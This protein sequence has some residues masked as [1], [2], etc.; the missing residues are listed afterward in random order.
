MSY[1]LVAPATSIATPVSV[2][3]GGT[4]AA[5]AAGAKTNLSAAGSGANADI[6]SMTGATEI[7]NASLKLGAVMGMM[8]FYGVDAAPQQAATNAP[9]MIQGGSYNA[10]TLNASLNSLEAGINE[11]LTALQTIGLIA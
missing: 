3:N 9:L 2:A 5:T 10:A 6:T 8:G 1:I 7:S 11:I 4:G